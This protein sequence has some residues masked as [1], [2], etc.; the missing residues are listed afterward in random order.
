MSKQDVYIP[1][2]KHVNNAEIFRSAD[3]SCWDNDSGYFAD[4]NAYMLVQRDEIIIIDL[5]NALTPG[6]KCRYVNVYARQRQ[7]QPPL[8]AMRKTFRDVYDRFINI[9]ELDNADVYVGEQYSIR[10]FMPFKRIKPIQTPQKWTIAHV[11]KAILSGQIFDGYCDGR[12]TDDY[13]YDASVHCH[14]GEQLHLPNF[15]QRLIEDP[16][17]WWVRVDKVDEPYIKLSVNCH[18]FDLNT[19]Y[20]S[21][22]RK[23]NLWRNETC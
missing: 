12:Y 8:F 5:T 20:F 9:K 2:Y 4:I 16:S 1:S 22:N 18:C 21:E 6:K 17:G 10:T 13:A 23:S 11:W 3:I 7:T 14:E 15:V 19:L